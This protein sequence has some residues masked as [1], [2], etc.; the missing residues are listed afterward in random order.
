M[1]YPFKRSFAVQ[2][3]LLLLCDTSTV[4]RVESLFYVNVI[5][6]GPPSSSDRALHERSEWVTVCAKSADKCAKAQVRKLVIPRGLL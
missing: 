1:S 3:K 5:V 6:S 4:R 2:D